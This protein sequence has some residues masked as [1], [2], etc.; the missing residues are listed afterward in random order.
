MSVH[1]DQHEEYA[2]RHNPIWKTSKT[3]LAHG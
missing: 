3:L 2:R 1:E